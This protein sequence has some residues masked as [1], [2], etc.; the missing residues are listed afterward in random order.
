MGSAHDIMEL[1]TERDLHRLFS[2]YD[3]WNVAPVNRSRP[4]GCF[5]RIFRKK[6]VGEEVAFVAVSFDRAPR[7]ETLAALDA[8]DDARETR[9]KKYL[10]TPQ[11]TDSSGVPP[12]VR[13][14]SMSAFAF[15]GGELVWLTKK[16][17]AKRF[18]QETAVTA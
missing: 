9:T 10:L 14:L 5:Y 13:V 8:L 7:E 17:N 18:V 6:W 11:A 2:D 1:F 15:A 3:G 12:H 4:T 16:Q